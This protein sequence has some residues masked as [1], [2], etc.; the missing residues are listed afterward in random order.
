MLEQ[1]LSIGVYRQSFAQFVKGILGAV[2]AE[3]AKHYEW[4]NLPSLQK[5]GV[6]NI[7]CFVLIIGVMISA[8]MYSNDYI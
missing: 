4:H 8:M 5:D 1:T 6:L 2:S 3:I 7:F